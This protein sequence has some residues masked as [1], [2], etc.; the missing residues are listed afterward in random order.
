MATDGIIAEVRKFR[1]ELAERFNYDAHA[2]LEDLR[3]R[4][5][6]SGR[7]VVLLPPKPVRK[8]TSK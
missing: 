7:K 4:Q 2:I 5:A 8:A 1:D 3:R 6:A